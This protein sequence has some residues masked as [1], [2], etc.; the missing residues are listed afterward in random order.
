L[1]KIA[2]SQPLDVAI[3]Q[4]QGAGDVP[5]VRVQLVT[6][7]LV[8]AISY[9]DQQL[10]DGTAEFVKLLTALVPLADL[11]LGCFGGIVPSTGRTVLQYHICVALQPV[12]FDKQLLAAAAVFKGQIEQIAEQSQV[13]NGYPFAAGSTKSK[14]A[15]VVCFF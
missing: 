11:R 10:Y 3:E 8:L 13:L 1:R 6:D 14:R 4:G 15:L 5:H 2:E 12:E 7:F 9:F